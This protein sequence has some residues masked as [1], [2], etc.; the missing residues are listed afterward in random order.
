VRLKKPIV[1]TIDGPAGAGKTTVSRILADRLGFRYID[2]G[3]LYR[4]IALA[5]KE[6]GISSDDD[7]TLEEMCRNLSLRFELISDRLKLFSGD[8]DITEQIRT[9]EITMMASAVSARPVVRTFLLDLQRLIGMEK[10]VIF[11]GR[12]MGTVVFPDAEV[13]FFLDAS[14]RTRAVRRFNEMKNSSSQTL[15]EVERDI[16]L[17]DRN[18][19]TRAVAPLKPA[20]DAVRIDTTDLSLEEVVKIML[21]AVEN[22]QSS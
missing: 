3:A 17:R 9:P 18:D 5:A 10:Q 16:V 7:S 12:D 8:R 19:S 4:G 22:A 14:P 2:T 13:K 20:A 15:E 1:I 6:Q 11:E 21:K